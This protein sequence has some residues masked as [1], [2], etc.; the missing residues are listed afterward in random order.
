[1]KTIAIINEK[2]GTGK[3]TVAVNLAAALGQRGHTVVL[4]DL[5]ARPNATEWLLGIAPDARDPDVGAFG[6]L[7]RD[8]PLL[9]TLTPTNEANLLLCAGH[10]QLQRAD[11]LL[12]SQPDATRVL[13]TALEEYGA[14]TAGAERRIDY[15]V[16]DSPGARNHVMF[17]A[18]LAADLIVTPVL[19]EAL[20]SMGLRE[21]LAMVALIQRRG[22]P[23]LP[24]PVIV[25]NHFAGRAG[26]NQEYA[27]AL[28]T[29][30]AGHVLATEIGR[31]AVLQESV[32]A[33]QSVL[34]YRP[35]SVPAAQM[36]SVAE[37]IVQRLD[38][39]AEGAAR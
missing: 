8:L 28:R 37:E 18:L 9:R 15:V 3:T 16:I 1:L 33:N 34:A 32:T 19:T 17:N 21:V 11:S 29:N 38:A 4:M 39:A 30:Y 7:T 20:N 6:L 22:R 10:P 31:T 2:G 14:S 23:T 26:L 13:A 12:A 27:E 36:R 35:R 25:I 5:D 24:H